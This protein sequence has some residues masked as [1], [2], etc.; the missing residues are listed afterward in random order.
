MNVFPPGFE[1]WSADRQ[2][3][4]ILLMAGTRKAEAEARK[5]E[6]EAEAQARK[7]EA[8]AEARKAEAEA[9][10]R[11][12]EAEARKAE[13]EAVA[14]KAEAEARKA[15]AEAEGRKAEI[16][17]AARNVGFG[18]LPIK[19]THWNSLVSHYIEVPRKHYSLDEF[20]LLVRLA[21]NDDITTDEF[22]LY[23]LPFDCEIDARILVD[24]TLRFNE[25]LD[26]ILAANRRLPSMFVWNYENSSP[27]KLPDDHEVE[28]TGSDVS[29]SSA[30]S[31]ACREA[32]NS[33]CLCC[34][35]NGKDK[36]H[37]A[38]IF[39]IGVYNQM[40]KKGRSFLRQLGLA[41]INELANLICLCVSCHQKFDNF[42]LGIDPTE[43]M[44]IVGVAERKENIEFGNRVHGKKIHFYAGGPPPESALVWKWRRFVEANN[45]WCCCFCDSIFPTASTTEQN[46]DD[47]KLNCKLKAM[48]ILEAENSRG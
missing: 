46:F 25:F 3:A 8:E 28:K 2:D 11:K 36:I 13:A 38:H 31:L 21:F 40:S 29:R 4:Y 16:D 12:A 26:T 15:E 39:D 42:R 14:R 18:V 45:A 19:V 43:K 20:R 33:T 47:H 27:A 34:G 35:Y 7:A 6:A 17:V 22:R 5:A 48:S 41:Y 23:L 1:S 24:T 37:A 10:A 32:Y 30:C 44:W 9:E